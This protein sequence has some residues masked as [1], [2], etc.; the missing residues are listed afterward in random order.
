MFNIYERGKEI[1]KIIADGAKT[2]PTLKNIIEIELADFLRSEKR[3]RM[4]QGNAYYVGKHD[5]LKKTRNGHFPDGEK[6][7]NSIII[8]NQYRKMVDQKTNFLLG[9]PVAIDTEKDEYSNLLNDVFNDK[10]QKQISQLGKNALNNG[11]A[12]LYVYV[13]MAGNLCFKVFPSEQ[14]LPFWKDDE[15]NE[16]E[17]AV[18]AY[19]MEVYSGKHKTIETFVEVYSDSGID[20]YVYSGGK[21]I[22]DVQKQHQAYF[23]VTEADG[24]EQGYNWDTIPLIAFKYNTEELPLIINCKT[25][26]DAINELY[27]TM[28]DTMIE[29]SRSTVLILKNYDGQDLKEFRQ[30]LNEHG[31][32]KVRTVSGIEGGV[33]SISIEFKPENHQIVLAILKKSMI[34]NC[35]GY[36]AKDD[37]IGSNANQMNIQSMYNDINLDAHKMEAEFQEALHKVLNIVNMYL[38][39]TGHGDYA[40]EKVDFVFNRDMMMNES[41]I[42]TTLSNLGLQLSQETLINQVP[43]ID[44]AKKEL[45]RVSEEKQQ[46]VNDYSALFMQGD[47]GGTADV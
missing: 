40:G 39:N 21:L 38:Y 19:E 25:I 14:I 46:N 6:K 28:Q 9:Q 45:E 20:Y 27:S 29:S 8:D 35:A 17:F 3:E 43:F 16:L 11:L 37:K 44:D 47:N 36:D 34:E 2:A 33:D 18:R 12:W 23:T 26:Q 30:K 4:L 31:V 32:I 5:I 24:K 1:L 42:M 7:P 15:H 13:D 10:F 41:E 22:E